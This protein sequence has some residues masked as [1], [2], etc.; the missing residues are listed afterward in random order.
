MSWIPHLLINYAEAL[1]NAEEAKTVMDG[2]FSFL[3][4]SLTG[5]R[6]IFNPKIGPLSIGTDIQKAQW[7]LLAFLFSVMLLLLMVL[8]LFL[9][10]WCCS[11]FIY[12]LPEMK[13]KL[14]LEHGELERMMAEPYLHLCYHCPRNYNTATQTLAV[15]TMAFCVGREYS[16]ELKMCV[17]P[18]VQP[19][20][21]FLRPQT[22][23]A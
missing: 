3:G 8:M 1:W 15:L 5:W 6:H 2:P 20:Q 10:C 13:N 7:P 19:A 14:F 4:R 9:R 22:H 12:S 17:H 21:L 23:H 16:R 18:P 11:S